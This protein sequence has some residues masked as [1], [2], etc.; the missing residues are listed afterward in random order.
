MTEQPATATRWRRGL[1]RVWLRH[2]PATRFLI[3]VCTLSLVA[4]AALWTRDLVAEAS[5]PDTVCDGLIRTDDVEGVGSARTV[6]PFMRRERRPGSPEV[7]CSVGALVLSAYVLPR[8]AGVVRDVTSAMWVGAA[9]VGPGIQGVT[10]R[11]AAWL[12]LPCPQIADGAPLFVSLQATPGS[13][14]NSGGFQ[15]TLLAKA[16][17][18]AARVIGERAGCGGPRLPDAVVPPAPK[19]APQVGG[20]PLGNGEDLFTFTWRVW[21]DTRKPLPSGPVCGVPAQALPSTGGDPPTSY[22]EGPGGGVLYTCTIYAGGTNT[23]DSARFTVLRGDLVRYVKDPYGS[24]LGTGPDSGRL[25]S[26]SAW[27]TGTCGGAPVLFSLKNGFRTYT[28][29][30]AETERAFRAFVADYTARE[31]CTADL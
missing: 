10:A 16:L 14:H 28:D 11:S 31:H 27:V 19:P 3:V 2:G 13:G 29:R 23:L 5:V 24:P 6:H 12:V 21:A 26:D 17:V 18:R 7:E 15:R 1:N 8:A 25:Q 9:P 22:A 20:Q 4:A 30:S